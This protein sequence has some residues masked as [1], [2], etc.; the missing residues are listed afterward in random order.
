MHQYVHQ[1]AYN[2]IMLHSLTTTPAQMGSQDKNF[3]MHLPRARTRH[4]FAPV[5]AFHKAA[6]TP[7]SS[8]KRGRCG[9]LHVRIAWKIYYQKKIKKMQQKPNSFHQDLTPEYPASSLPDKESEQPSCFQPKIAVDVMSP[10]HSSLIQDLTCIPT[11]LLHGIQLGM[12]TREW[13]STLDNIS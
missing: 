2:P 8:T 5:T 11:K 3:N 7:F 10:E 6:Q 13:I 9:A 4:S 12:F 1:H